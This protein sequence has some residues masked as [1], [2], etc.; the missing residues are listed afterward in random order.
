MILNE[1]AASSDRSVVSNTERIY[2]FQVLLP[3]AST[4]LRLACKP[5]AEQV[6]SVADER[7][8]EWV[9]LVPAPIMFQMDEALR[10][11]LAL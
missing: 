8:G 1:Q 3:P 4:G 9:G 10:L 5:Q 7:V 11:H 2:P 6:R